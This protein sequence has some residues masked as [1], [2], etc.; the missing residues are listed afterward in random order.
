MNTYIVI[1]AY[2][3]EK[4]I[5]KVIQSAKKFGNIVVVDDYSKDSTFE[6]AVASGVTVLRHC[7]NRGQGASLQT[8]VDFALEKNA[9]IIV[10]LDSDSQHDPN[11]IPAIIKPILENHAEVVLGSRFVDKQTNH[12]IP[13][14]RLF[15]LKLATI[16]TKIVS[17]INITDTH[18][19]FRA[20]SGSAISKIR[21]TQDRMA[22]A[23]EI[24][25][26]I[27]KNKLKYTE[28][29]VNIH[30]SSET[31]AKGQKNLGFIKILFDII[32]SK[33]FN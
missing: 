17:G 14:S 19:G 9:D 6:K 1:P 15:L 23:S 25:D 8:G 5:A 11:Q 10:H 13:K 12:T 21:I 22:H 24:L 4:N 29:P 20:F 7:I 3:E 31:I 26:E 28:I 16:F 18:N 27:V 30:Y 33:I 2:N 32:K